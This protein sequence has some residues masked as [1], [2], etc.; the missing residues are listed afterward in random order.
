[1]NRKAGAVAVGMAALLASCMV[2]PK[3]SKPGVPTAPS[4]SEQPPQSYQGANGWKAAQPS[5]AML[6]GK[7]WEMFGDAQL[8][9][10]EE[11]V[12][13]ANQ[14]LKIAEANFR[15]A[16][17]AIRYNRSFEYPTVG[18]GPSITRNRVSS[19]SPT[20][21]AGEG[22]GNFVFPI[23]VSYDADLWGRVRRTV[24][25]AREQFRRRR[26]ISRT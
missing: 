16:R 13:P 23:S 10:L 7:W 17:A 12:A 3:Y 14:T 8:N 5:D 22:Y 19:N 4:Y 21:F 11:Q 15:E 25:Q 26:P 20:G 18:A 9:A 1:M 6:R 24:T 2:G